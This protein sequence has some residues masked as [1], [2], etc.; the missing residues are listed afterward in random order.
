MNAKSLLTELSA[1]P[2]LCDGAMGTQLIAHGLQ[3]G[4]CGERWNVD[5]P[6][7]VEAIHRSYHDAG[8]DLIT[9]NTFGASAPALQRHDLDRRAGELNRA[10]AELATRAAGPDAWVLGD[11]GPFGG[12]LQPIG[13]TEPQELLDIFKQQAAALYLGGADAVIVETMSDPSELAIAVR[14]AKAVSDRPVIATYAFS[15]GAGAHFRTMMGTPPDEAVAQAVEAGADVVGAN[16]GTSLNLADYLHLGEQ[17]VRAAGNRS[18]ILQPNAGSPR[19]VDGKLVYP[20]SP[21]DMADLVAPLLRAGLRII[22][23]CCGTTPE[24]LRAMAKAL[25]AEH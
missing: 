11:I 13:D 15:R 20:A 14:A 7:I 5:R 24:H 19:M 1:R 10:G 3:P 18:V 9:T 12:F 23:G 8:C 22:G 21:Q 25:T 4:A 2:L 6:D 17:L 16:C